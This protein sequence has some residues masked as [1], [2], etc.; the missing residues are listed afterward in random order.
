MSL[1]SKPYIQALAAGVHGGIDYGELERLG[2]KPEEIVDFSVNAN[3][4]GPPQVVREALANAAI[5]RYPDSEAMDLRRR[6]ASRHGVGVENILVANGSVEVIWAACLAYLGPGDC[7]LLC[8]PTFGEYEVAS[9][10]CGAGA[11][12]LDAEAGDGFRPP[13][14]RILSALA[15]HRPKVVFVCN[16]NNPTG[17]YLSR[18]EVEGILVA[19]ADSLVVLDEAYVDFV[20]GRW[21]SID[22]LRHDNLLVLRSM[23]KDFAIAGLRL[24]YGLAPPE[25][26]RCIKKARPPWS[27]NAVAQ[28]AGIAALGAEGFLERS[29]A[30]IAQAR[31]YL[32]REFRRL[33]FPVIDSR[34]NF[35]LARVG[36]G[37]R[38]RAALLS[39]GLLVRDCAS[40]GLPAY[41]RIA[42]RR[43]EECQRLVE[44]VERLAARAG[45]DLPK[46]H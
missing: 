41:V 43:L 25:I 27:V 28:A 33:G 3:P 22:L 44:E 37:K 8:G 5:D 15:E 35:F 24:G 13:V 17:A 11:L 7:A 38:F 12:R 46:G 4:F 6:L 1:T 39:K 45:G 26:I 14:A 42:P 31:D 21:S 18:A 23:T 30:L 34:A 19:A 40:F 10:L 16:P 29:V 2:L 32:T 9:R 20:S 36:D